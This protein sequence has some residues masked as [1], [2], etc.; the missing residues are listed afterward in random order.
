MDY[1]TRY[2]LPEGLPKNGRVLLSTRTVSHEYK[3]KGDY[4]GI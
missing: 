4:Y 1:L 3:K 2:P